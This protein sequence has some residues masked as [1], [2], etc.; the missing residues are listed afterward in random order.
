M[1]PLEVAQEFSDQFSQKKG[2]FKELPSFAIMV[3]VMFEVTV[4]RVGHSHDS[5]GFDWLIYRCFYEHLE[6]F[7]SILSFPLPST[8]KPFL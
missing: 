2:H 5:T 3:D 1:E 4:L 7:E 6:H 8:V